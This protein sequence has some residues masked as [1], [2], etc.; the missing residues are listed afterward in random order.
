[1]RWDGKPPH[2]QQ[3][4]VPPSAEKL[5]AIHD[6]VAGVISFKAERGDQLIVETL[7]F[8]ATLHTRA[9]G[10]G[11]ALRPPPRAAPVARVPAWLRSPKGMAAAA[12]GAI[13][14][15]VLVVVGLRRLPPPARGVGRGRTGGLG[16]RVPDRRRPR[17]P[18]RFRGKKMQAQMG[19]PGRHAG[20][21][22]SRSAGSHQSAR[23]GHQ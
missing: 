21:P 11:G 12:G 9:P 4:L 5:K 15:L 14:L 13:L 16:A 19:R 3:V 2:L 17:W 10:A 20:A 1:M 6:L 22:G 23:P 7:P 8:E 18:R